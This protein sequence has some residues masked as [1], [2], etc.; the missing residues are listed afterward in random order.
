MTQLFSLVRKNIIVIHIAMKSLRTELIIISNKI[1]FIFLVKVF[2]SVNNGYYTEA[3][4]SAQGCQRDR[5]WIRFP[6]K[7]MNYYF[8]FLASRCIPHTAG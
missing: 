7:E 1:Y 3:I 2:L 6:L 8:F 4:R 5:S